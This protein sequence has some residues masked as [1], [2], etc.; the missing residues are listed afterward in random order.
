MT[1]LLHAV[2]KG[3][4]ALL[5]KPVIGDLW[6]VIVKIAVTAG[7]GDHGTRGDDARTGKLAPINGIT[8]ID[9]DESCRSDIANRGEAGQ[10]VGARIYDGVEGVVEGHVFEA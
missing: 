2:G 5:G 4:A 1:H 7:D 9:C 10:Q 3:K 6:G 8:G